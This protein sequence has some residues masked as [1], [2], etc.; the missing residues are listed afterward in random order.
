MFRKATLDS[1]ALHVLEVNCKEHMCVC[2][3][4]RACACVQVR[5]RLA[6]AI[7]A[8]SAHTAAYRAG[9]EARFRGCCLLP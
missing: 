6:L 2:A 8:L 7:V 5:R 9:C 4:V 1:Q 3:C